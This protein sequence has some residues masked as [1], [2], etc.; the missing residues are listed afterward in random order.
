MKIVSVRESPQRIPAF[1]EYFTK[2]WASDA[3]RPIYQNCIENAP[4]AD[5]CLP[6]WYLLENEAGVTIG[7]AGIIT[8]DFISRMDLLPWLCALHVEPLHRR[9]GHGA[10]LIEHVCAETKRFGFQSVHL[11]TE[12]VGYYERH[13]FSYVGDGYHPWGSSSKIYKRSLTRH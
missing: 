3:T 12:H 1:V 2:C 9:M 10:A 6:Q 7:G 8:N 11:C 4:F 5:F 13:G